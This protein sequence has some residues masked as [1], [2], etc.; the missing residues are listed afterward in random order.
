MKRCVAVLLVLAIVL[1]CSGCDALIARPGTNQTFGF[2]LEPPEKGEEIAIMHTNF[3][4]IYIRLFPKQAPLAV[5]NFKTLAKAGYYDGVLFHRIIPD[6]MIQSGDPTGSGNGGES[7][8]GGTFEDEF[9][10]ELG[11]L[12]GALS[13]S[14]YDVDTNGSQFFINQA[15]PEADYSVAEFRRA[16]DSDVDIRS[17]YGS[18]EAFLANRL[19]LKKEALTDEVLKIYEEVGGNIHLDGTRTD[20]LANTVFGQVFDGMD[21]VDAI[22]AV[23]TNDNSFPLELVCV[24]SIEFTEYKG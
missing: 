2:Q 4:D 23:E 6:F 13:M 21:V 14:N 8:W 1:L 11:N 3:G 10:E 5:E 9:C 16:Y 22:A 12:R 20:E 15:G 17:T 7:C 19:T 18:F 24:D